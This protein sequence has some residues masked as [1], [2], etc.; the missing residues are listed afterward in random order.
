VAGGLATLAS[1]SG[2]AR[3]L[4]TSRPSLAFDIED[5]FNST[6]NKWAD[7]L[8]E[9]DPQA[10]KGGKGPA[11]AATPPELSDEEAAEVAR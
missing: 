8:D 11:G 5:K 2:L 6:G 9:K 3:A 7:L 1:R 10:P 4:S